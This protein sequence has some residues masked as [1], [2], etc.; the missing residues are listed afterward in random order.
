MS[1][2]LPLLPARGLRLW[3]PL[4]LGSAVATMRRARGLTKADLARIVAAQQDRNFKVYYTQLH[5]W[6]DGIRH[7]VPSRMRPLLDGL[8]VHL[9]LLPWPGTERRP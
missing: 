8:Q 7:P 4:Q 2:Q 5:A 1:D 3:D 9:A 6:E